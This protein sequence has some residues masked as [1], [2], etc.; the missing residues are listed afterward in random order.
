MDEIFP[1]RHVFPYKYFTSMENPIE[2]SRGLL[3]L[4]EMCVD[5]VVG[6]ALYIYIYIFF[7]ILY[8][9]CDN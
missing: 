9:R 2:D 5:C 4:L 8:E 3:S 6:A 1:I 7:F